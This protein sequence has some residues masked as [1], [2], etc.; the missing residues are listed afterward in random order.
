MKLIKWIILFC[1]A[2]LAAAIFNASR[3][4]GGLEIGRSRATEDLPKQQQKVTSSQF[5]E[6]GRSSDGPGGVSKNP[7]VE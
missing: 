2:A 1:A 6:I 5:W 7:Y 4:D 3:M